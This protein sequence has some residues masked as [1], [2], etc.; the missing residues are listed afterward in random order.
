MENESLSMLG[1]GAGGEA[2]L[3]PVLRVRV[4]PPGPSPQPP[5]DAGLPNS[6]F[7]PMLPLMKDKGPILVLL[8]VAVGLG[9]ALIV[10]NK[11]ASDQAQEAADKL[12]VASNTVTSVK[13][14]MSELEVVNQ[15][16]ESNLTTTRVDF[17]NKISLAD[18]NLKS[19]EADLE[20]TLA[21]AK[22]EKAMADSNSLALAEKEQK[23]TDLESRNE[24][25]DK[26][27]ASLHVAM[28]NL[29]A[30]IA[31]TQEKLDKSEGDR[32]FLLKELATLQAERADLEN[33]FNN[34]RDVREQLHKLKVE[35]ALTRRLDSMRKEMYGSFKDQNVTSETS[36]A[37][38]EVKQSGGVK[39]QTNTV[40]VPSA[41]PP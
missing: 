41:P 4:T 25:L 28:T 6:P 1:V 2:V 14:Q 13:K 21:E 9:I 37:V 32:A 35:A 38:I 24:A 5:Q 27:A 36:S 19:T 10:V 26:E 34:I 8:L 31:V 20:K 29:D 17:S 15:T 12:A 23:I 22:A 18:A 7:G 33:R 3:A 40:P 30:K 39:I 11:E 16:L